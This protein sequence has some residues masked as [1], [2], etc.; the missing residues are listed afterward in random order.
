MGQRRLLINEDRAGR[1]ETGS[2]VQQDLHVLQI[3]VVPAIAQNFAGDRSIRDIGQDRTQIGKEALGVL[4]HREM[5]KAL[6]DGKID[7]RE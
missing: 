7:P 3:V 1:H 6:H 4:A 2:H 5:S